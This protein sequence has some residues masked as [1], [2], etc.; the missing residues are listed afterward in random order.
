M[1]LH[2]FNARNKQPTVV[3]MSRALGWTKKKAYNVTHY[4]LGNDLITSLRLLGMNDHRL[5]LTLKGLRLL[6]L[7]QSENIPR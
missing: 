5:K 7:Y 1:V 2:G 4:L 6:R 3:E